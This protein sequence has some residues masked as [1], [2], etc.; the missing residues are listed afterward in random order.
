[1]PGAPR[2]L[3]AQPALASLFERWLALPDNVRGA[4]WVIA[5]CLLFGTMAAIVKALG[6]RLDSF[7]LA[8]LRAFFLLLILLPFVARAGVG[9]LRTARPGLHTARSLAGSIGLM[10]GFYGLTHLKLAD[11]TALSF[12]QPL[13]LIVLAALVLRELV[14]P[15]R[16][17]ATAVGFLG[18]LIMLRPGDGV[19]EFAAVVAV[20]GALAA[21]V[22]KLLIKQLAQTEAPLAIILYFALIST[23]ITAI[24]AAFVWQPPALLDLFGMAAAAGCAS[25]AQLCMIRGYKI[26]EASALAPLEYVRLPLAAVYGFFFFAEIPDLYSLLGAA[27]IVAGTLY[28]ARREAHIGRRAHAPRTAAAD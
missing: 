16:W 26:G 2:S 24:P 4:L 17:G 11:A 1:M 20:L 3:A 5:S 14:G 28:I 18:V 13:F 22:V 12:T 27:L 10:C 19:L 15:R 21:A 8:F 9:V 23:A 6:S 25:L 7:Q